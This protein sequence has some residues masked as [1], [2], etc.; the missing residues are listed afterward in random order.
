M[1]KMKVRGA[2]ETFV[3]IYKITRLHI[4]ED[5]TLKFNLFQNNTIILGFRKNKNI[6]ISKL[7]Y[8]I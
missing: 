2:S 1:L 7:N 5:G 8:N 4:P 3:S 6:K